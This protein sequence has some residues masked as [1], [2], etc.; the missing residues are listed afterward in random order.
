MF[1]RRS[2]ARVGAAALCIFLAPTAPAQ[3]HYDQ[4]ASD[5]EVVIGNT[6]PYS[7][8]ASGLGAI[9]KTMSAYFRKIND[10]GGIN[11]RKIRFISLDDA[12]SPPKTVEMTRQLIENEGVLF[13]GGSL[14][15]ATN[16]SVQKYLND[17]KIPQLA[18]ISGASRWNDPTHFP[19]SMPVMLN[20]STEA[21]IYGGHILRTKPDAK[22]AVLYQN[23]DFGKDCLEGLKEGLGEKAKKMIVAEVS[24]E[25]SD[26]T[27]DSQ[28]M[29]LQASGADVFV[30]FSLPKFTAMAIRKVYDIGWRPVQYVSTSSISIATVMTAAGLEKSKGVL[31]AA[32]IKEPTDPQWQNDRAMNEWRDFM[33]K[34]NADVSPNDIQGVAGYA[35]AQVIAQVI[36]QCGDNLTRENVMRQAGNLKLEAGVGLPGII[37]STSP[38]NYAPLHAAQL[39]R[40]DGTQ[41]VRFGDVIS[42]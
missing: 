17:R 34:Y 12:Y 37:F 14:G 40:F 13:M 18:I 6:M 26:P 1:T 38:T 24:Y 31:S 5:A 33:K 11:G 30:G 9:G 35:I 22:I 7:G 36:T 32:T 10:D 3:K 4:G 20:Y 21:W 39:M 41:W 27:I 15:T 2:F 8:P 19:W 23:D 28:I 42:R 16:I 29:Q 25:T